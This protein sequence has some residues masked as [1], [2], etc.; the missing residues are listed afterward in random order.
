[1]ADDPKQV[2][3]EELV[4]SNMYS[5]EALV[6]LLIEKGIL[7]KEEIIERIKEVGQEH[8]QS[9]KIH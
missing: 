8:Q 6:R 9:R 3:M 5:I 4:V 1:M 2:S 7:D